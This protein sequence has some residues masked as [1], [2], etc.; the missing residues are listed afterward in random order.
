MP[1]ARKL[2]A[3]WETQDGEALSQ[4]GLP[5]GF[6]RI[7]GPRGQPPPALLA[8]IA[9]SLSSALTPH[10]P[11]CQGR[12]ASLRSVCREQVNARTCTGPLD[13]LLLAVWEPAQPC[14]T[15]ALSCV[16]RLVGG[17][18]EAPRPDLACWG[19]TAEV[20]LGGLDPHVNPVSVCPPSIPTPG[21]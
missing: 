12:A 8:R 6:L 18:A 19:H 5:C 9:G 3:P 21:S 13:G 1:T 10:Q 7:P 20:G 2:A 11:L 4:P 16:N 17:G 15:A 14:P